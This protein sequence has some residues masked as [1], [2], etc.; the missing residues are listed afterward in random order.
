V[1]AQAVDALDQMLD[2]SRESGKQSVGETCVDL[3]RVIE[4]SVRYQQAA[5][6]L[7]RNCRRGVGRLSKE[8]NFA[9]GHAGPTSVYD[10]LA[11]AA[12][13]HDSDFAF[14][15]KCQSGRLIARDP[16]DFPSRIGSLDAA[17]EKCRFPGR[18]YRFEN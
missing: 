11:S 13:S 6:W 4:R 2:S 15:N 8:W 9:E 1:R 10:C 12:S 18:A 16:Q 7:G 14:D 3:E 5:R 17:L